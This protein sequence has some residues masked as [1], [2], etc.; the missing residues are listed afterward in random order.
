VPFFSISA[1]RPQLDALASAPLEHETLDGAAAH[2]A[3][4]L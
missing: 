2:A 3:A 4:S 1:H